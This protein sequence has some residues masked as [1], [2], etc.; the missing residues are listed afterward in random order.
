MAT[1]DQA[2]TGWVQYGAGGGGGN[3]FVQG[4][5][6]FGAT[7]V[8]GTT[9]SQPLRL[10]APTI[11]LAATT[12]LQVNGS[13]GVLGQV[14]TSQGP[15][16]PAIWAPAGGSSVLSL[17]E[18]K[19]LAGV[20]NTTFAGLNGDADLLYLM[21]GELTVVGGGTQIEFLV[22]GVSSAAAITVIDVNSAS[23]TVSGAASNS[24]GNIRF[25]AGG[26]VSPGE[27][28]WWMCRIDASRGS[29]LGQQ[30]FQL[31]VN[32]ATTVPSCIS[33]QIGAFY[34]GAVANL[35]SIQVTNTAGSALTGQISLYKL[36]RT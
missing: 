30:S 18:T 25:P 33:Q 6:A 17:V 3:A 10:T 24:G 14:L 19:T 32:Q 12:A 23:G 35:T 34:R 36:S 9:D 20:T 15:G 5:N 29:T 7:A 13:A 26:S 8:L 4:G 28:L 22:N 16:A 1:P 11:N 31:E 21:E 2:F 27:R